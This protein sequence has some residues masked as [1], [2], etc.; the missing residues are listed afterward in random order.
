MKPARTNLACAP[1]SA[2]FGYPNPI[3]A[4]IF[5]YIITAKPRVE[6][7]NDLNGEAPFGVV[8]VGVAPTGEVEV[9]VTPTAAG[10]VD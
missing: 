9:R 3:M 5:H 1:K 7:S 10:V 4:P 2:I 8:E 6:C